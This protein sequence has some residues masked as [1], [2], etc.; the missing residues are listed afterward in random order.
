V[1]N[2]LI[3]FLKPINPF[4]KR[5]KGKEKEVAE[6]E[7]GGKNREEEEERRKKKKEEGV[8]QV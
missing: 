6:R 2:I 7:L 3:I 1:L 5:Q 8:V 4:S